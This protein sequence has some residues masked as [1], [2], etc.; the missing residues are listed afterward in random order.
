MATHQVLSGT[1]TK[2]SY[3]VWSQTIMS[4]SERIS[5]RICRSDRTYTPATSCDRRSGVWPWPFLA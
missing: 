1:R 2:T 5:G 3:N 4:V